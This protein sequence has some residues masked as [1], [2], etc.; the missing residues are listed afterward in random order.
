MTIGR[1]I[2]CVL[3]VLDLAPIAA[4]FSRSGTGDQVFDVPTSVSRVRVQA[5]YGGDCQNFAIKI[6]GR[7]V[8]NTVLGSCPVASGRSFDGTYTT[9]GG[10]GEVVSSTGVQWVI[11]EVQ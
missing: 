11:S 1:S 2:A 10:V 7:L 5:T 4:A 6:Q 8:V 3:I 9:T